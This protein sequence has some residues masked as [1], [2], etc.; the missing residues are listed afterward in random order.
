VPP[1]LRWKGSQPIRNMAGIR[2]GSQLLDRY[3]KILYAL[4]IFCAMGS[5]HS[6]PAHNS[7][8]DGSGVVV[9]WVVEK[10][11]FT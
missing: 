5:K 11:L 9:V 1:E 7:S 8:R 10:K 2:S 3:R 4:L 6:S